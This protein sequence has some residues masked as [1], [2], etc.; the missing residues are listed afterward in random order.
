MAGSLMPILITSYGLQYL[1]S[2]SNLLETMG[3]N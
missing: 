2:K 1:D 3:C